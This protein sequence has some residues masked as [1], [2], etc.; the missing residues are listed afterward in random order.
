MIALPSPSRARPLLVIL[1]CLLVG[2]PLFLGSFLASSV[3]RQALWPAPAPV[4]MA[5]G[6]DLTAG[7][8]SST[9]RQ[10]EAL[11]GRLKQQP[12]DQRSLTT[13]GLAY[14]QKVRESGDPSFYPRAEGA[15]TKA[16]ESAP[17]DADT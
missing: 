15:L 2:L 7:G 3:A 14:L 9:D 12:A 17:N 11:Q 4:P 10:I 13:L 8:V 5:P 6:A 16:L 1:A